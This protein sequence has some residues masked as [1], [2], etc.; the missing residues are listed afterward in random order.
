[1]KNKEIIEIA[2]NR[3]AFHDY[4]IEDKVEAGISLL[5]SEVKS[6]RNHAVSFTDSYAEIKKNEVFLHNLHISPYKQAGIFNHDPKRIKK[7]LLHRNQILRFSHKL[8]EKGYTLIPLRLYFSGKVV[9]VEL[10]LA[11]GKK[12]YEKK[13]DIKIREAQKE[14]DRALTKSLKQ[15]WNIK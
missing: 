8:K 12:K 2:T 9:K 14:I 7:L 11:R 15:Q 6:C 1:M 4:N 5:G 3:R 13:E 10:A